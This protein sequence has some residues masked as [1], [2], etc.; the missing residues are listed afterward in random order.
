MFTNKALFQ[1]G[2]TVS[3][4]EVEQLREDLREMQNKNHQLVEDNIKLT[5][6]L[7][8]LDLRST[9]APTHHQRML[10][11]TQQHRGEHLLSNLFR[12]HRRRLS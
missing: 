7:N 2:S 4:R 6:H 9:H 11:S 10:P 5:E 12:C 1:S 8:D 3:R